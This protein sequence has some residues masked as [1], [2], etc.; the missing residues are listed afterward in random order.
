VVLAPRRVCPHLPPGTESTQSSQQARAHPLPE[1]GPGM[2]V[3]ALVSRYPESRHWLTNSNA[4]EW[5][6]DHRTHA[7]VL[8]S[9]DLGGSDLNLRTADR[10]RIGESALSPPSRPLLAVVSV[11]WWFAECRHGRSPRAKGITPSK[12]D[13]LTLFPAWP[14]T[15]LRL[16]PNPDLRTSCPTYCMSPNTSSGSIVGPRPSSSRNGASLGVASNISRVL[17]LEKEWRTSIIVC[18]RLKT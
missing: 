7:I 12:A 17:R 6:R 18:V 16:Y 8:D 5:V 13:L 9:S 1:L 2:C 15:D 3:S 11:G 14:T 4:R 10:R